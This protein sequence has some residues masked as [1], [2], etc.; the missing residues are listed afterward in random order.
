MHKGRFGCC[1]REQIL[2]L[3][4]NQLCYR[5]S[6][7]NYLM[8]LL[9]PPYFFTLYVG[10]LIGAAFTDAAIG[11]IKAVPVLSLVSMVNTGL[12]IWKE[13]EGE[14]D[15]LEIVRKSEEKRDA[16]LSIVVELRTLTGMLPKMQ[17]IFNAV[18][19]NLVF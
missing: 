16:T 9:I 6:F 2:K 5:Q 4:L 10:L 15:Y 13:T 8:F 19:L 14:G 1:T 3:S 11:L 17:S 12:K 18:F 7:L